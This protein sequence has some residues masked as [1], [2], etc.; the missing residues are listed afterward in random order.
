MRSID[1]GR[2]P[3]ASG[4]PLFA[5]LAVVHAQAQLPTTLRDFHVPG[6]QIGDVSSAVLL[7]ANNCR[8]CHGNY[9]FANEPSFTWAGSL[10]ALAG[11]DPLFYAQLATA[12]QDAANVGYY[13][14][15]CHVPQS[16]VTGHANQAAGDT[17]DDQDLRGV[18]CH[19]CHSLVDPI[20]R[21][22]I[23][24]P[25]DQDIL[26]GLADAPTFFGNAMFV[27]DSTGTRRGPYDDAVAPHTFLPSPFHRRGDFCGTCHDVGNVA[28]ARQ[29]DG[30]YRY[31]ALDTPSPGS[32]P[33]TQFP[34]ER[35][36]TE[37]N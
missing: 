26:A 33:W 3:R 11:R 5:C 20:Y 10:M 1:A 6:T 37:W 9:D 35:T 17:L 7:D 19:F 16:I 29:P 4:V 27:L 15:R 28:T 18:D 36:Y 25:E 12:N 22:G 2:C 34:L 8:S 14:L 31:N 13:C 32:D 30:T 23:S 21:P 24:P